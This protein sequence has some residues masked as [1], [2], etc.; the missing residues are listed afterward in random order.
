MF[1]G[2]Y[3]PPSSIKVNGATFFHIASRHSKVEAQE[4]VRLIRRRGIRVRLVHFPAGT[5]LGHHFGVYAT[6]RTYAWVME[7]K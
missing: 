4:V 6:K 2:P 7:L 1:R 3:H 5:S